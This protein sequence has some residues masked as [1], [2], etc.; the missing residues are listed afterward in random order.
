MRYASGPNIGQAITNSLGLNG[1]SLLARV[2][3]F[4]TKLNSLDIVTNDLRASRVYDIGKGELT[5][6]AGFYKSRQ[7][8]DTDWL[9]TSKLM[10]VR[11]DGR[12]ALVDVVDA[13]GVPQTQNGYYAFGADY[14]RRLLSSQR[15]RRLQCQRTVGVAGTTRSGVSR[16]APA[17]ATI[18]A[19]HADRSS[20]RIWAAVVS[21]PRRGT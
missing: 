15:P 14:Y 13:A 20:D 17:S 5:T 7:T 18:S 3:V 10:D 16:W 1:N 6:T 19:M 12:A 2:V 21:A 8:I 9:W 11:G 4:D